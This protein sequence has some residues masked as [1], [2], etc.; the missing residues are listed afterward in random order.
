[1]FEKLTPRERVL[2]KAVLGLLPAT[3]IF[4]GIF[5][6]IGKYG[7]NNDEIVNLM[8]QITA[9][10]EKLDEAFKAN[11]RRSY[12]NSV[13]LPAKFEDASNDYQIWLKL[14]LA[15]VDMELKTLTP[16]DASPLKFKKQEVANRKTFAVTAAGNLEQLTEFLNRFYQVDL[17]HRINS[18]KV[19]PLNEVAGNNKKI[20]TGELSVNITIEVLSLATADEEREFT[21]Q[22]RELGHTR[23]EY[24]AA[25]LRRNIFGPANNT[26]VLSARPSSSYTSE[27]DAKINFTAK[28]ADERD[29]LLFEIVES[30][31]EGA[32]LQVR[33]GSRSASLVV[34][35]QKAGKYDFKVKVTDNG[36]PPKDNFK[37]I[38]VTFKDRVVSKPKPPA[39]P[40]PPFVNAKETRITAIVRDKAG[41]WLVW[42]KV[43]TTGERYK[44]KVGESFELD[45]QKWAVEAIK[46]E[47]AVL[48]V[49]DKKLLT[50]QPRD[51][52]VE[53]RNEVD[54][55]PVSEVGSEVETNTSKKIESDE[56]PKPKSIT[57]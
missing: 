27:K 5:W 32:E 38:T 46:P 52:F 39:P 7:D 30:S 29:E 25:V 41:D 6:F 54:L 4:I 42:I 13:S 28:D 16:R 57:S 40:K 36:F 20:R 12:Y 11:R 37:D 14:L 56:P 49:D 8:N 55:A 17:L 50:F 45:N 18:L 47:E 1:M 48:R 33:D 34:P 24:L 44:L 19:I 3:L 26:P 15:D 2:A 21:K 43:R 9:E 35:G 10:E 22:T 51:V 23:D 31:V 53:P